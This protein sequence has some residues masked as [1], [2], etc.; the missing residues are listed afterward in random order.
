MYYPIIEFIEEVTSIKETLLRLDEKV[1][2]ADLDID[3]SWFYDLYDSDLDNPK[4]I[5][6]YLYIK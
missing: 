3:N 4:R 6:R 1:N 5:I 2:G